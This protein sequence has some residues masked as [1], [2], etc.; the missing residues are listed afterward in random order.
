VA[1]GIYLGGTTGA[2][3]GTLEVPGDGT[4]LILGAIGSVGTI[5]IRAASGKQNAEQV[6][7]NAPA[8]CEV[9][10]DGITYAATAVYAIGALQD[11]N[12]ALYVKRTAGTDALTTGGTTTPRLSLITEE[13]IP[14]P[15]TTAPVLSG[16]LSAVAGD[17]Q[18]T[19]SGP[20]ASDAVGIAKWQYRIGTGVWV[21]VAS[22]SGTFPSTV[23]SDLTNG[24]AYSFTVR[25]L[26][27]AGNAS[28]ASNAASA[29][30]VAPPVT[31][32][33]DFA[34]G[35]L[36]TT[37][38]DL[39]KT[40]SATAIENGTTLALTSPSTSDGFLL[41]RKT[42][43]TLSDTKTYKWKLRLDS[44]QAWDGLFAFILEDTNAP[45]GPT[46]S[47]AGPSHGRQTSLNT[48]NPSGALSRIDMYF[49]YNSGNPVCTLARSTNVASGTN[50]AWDNATQAWR[51]ASA[52]SITGLAQDTDYVVVFDT[53]QETGVNK[54]RV[55]LMNATETTTLLDSGWQDYNGITS[56]VNTTGPF[57]VVATDWYTNVWTAKAVL[58]W[59]DEV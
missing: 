51:E 4:G 45:F 47:T 3:D 12:V 33:D 56:F 55:R 11:V 7:V 29:T 14:V 27:A 57:L 59:Y 25:A 53:K 20:T 49:E 44:S 8:N 9:S 17:T 10:A 13:V 43:L 48:G 24:T 16:T 23:V 46:A 34:D 54:W 2:A 22:T 42:R 5:H 39:Q 37:L 31:H 26:D 40:A 58:D 1:L 32:T 21:D 18:V 35:A 52:P 15:D 50:R 36:S 28:A 19:L 30:P 6:T 38:W 41:Y